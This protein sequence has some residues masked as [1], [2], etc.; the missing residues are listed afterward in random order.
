[1]AKITSRWTAERKSK[2]AALPTLP[3]RVAKPPSYKQ[4]DTPDRTICVRKH[5]YAIDNT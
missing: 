2:H 1:L 3:L 5:S 4:V